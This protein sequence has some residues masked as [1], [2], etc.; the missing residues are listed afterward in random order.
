M[1]SCQERSQ[2]SKTNCPDCGVPP[3]TIHIGWCDMEQC[4]NCG[5]QA[6]LCCCDS[7]AIAVRLPWDGEW[8]G[9]AECLE[10][11]WYAR[12]SPK[13]WVPCS[14]DEPRAWPDLNRLHLEA[15]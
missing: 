4:A 8:P 6:I 5:G 2:M 12:P 13:G 14:R 3:G 11:G 9:I 1:G 7:E 10:F 15:E